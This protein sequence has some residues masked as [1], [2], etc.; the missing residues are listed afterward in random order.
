VGLYTAAVFVAAPDRRLVTLRNVGLSLMVGSAVVLILR[1]ISV[2]TTVEFVVGDPGTRPIASVAG[3]VATSA[4]RQM[5]WS[6]VIYGLIIA[7]VATL[8]GER[9]WAKAS[10]RALAP[11][12]NSSVG[13]VTGRTILLLLLLL[14]WSPGRVFDSLVTGITFVLLVIAAVAAL[15]RATLREFPTE[16]MGDVATSAS[17]AMSSLAPSRRTAE[18]D[19]TVAQQLRALR[20]LHNSGDLAQDEY[21]KAKQRVLDGG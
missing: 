13:F 1:L 21:A 20:D 8:L 3:Y 7:A 2:R 5:A 18:P 15:R 14:W 9:R 4:M 12:L 16:T 17:I 10:R 19:S 11:A 6:G